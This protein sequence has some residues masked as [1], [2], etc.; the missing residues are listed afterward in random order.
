MCLISLAVI[1]SLAVIL[2]QWTLHLCE[3]VCALLYMSVGHLYTNIILWMDVFLAWFTLVCAMT[4]QV[5]TS[6][7]SFTSNADLRC[8][9]VSSGGHE[10]LSKWWEMWVRLLAVS[11][12]RGLVDWAALV[13]HPVGLWGVMRPWYDF[14]FWCYVYCLLVYIYL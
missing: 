12:R 8:V 6:T 13:T 10:K 4:W 14:W 3:Y 9:L 1:V 7:F 5:A 2:L 11:I